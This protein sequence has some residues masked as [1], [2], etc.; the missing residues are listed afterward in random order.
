[1]T[2]KIIPYKGHLNSQRNENTD[3]G[4]CAPILG[5]SFQV[6]TGTRNSSNAPAYGLYDYS[7]YAAIWEYDELG[8]T[9]LN[10]VPMQIT[11]INI[12]IAGYSNGYTYNNQTIKLYHVVESVF[13]NNGQPI[14][15][16][17]LTIYD[18]TIVK[19][20]FTWTIFGSGWKSFTFDTNFCYNGTDNLLLVWENRDGSWASGFGH[21][22][23][24]VAVDKAADDRADNAFPT[25]N[26]NL[27]TNARINIQFKK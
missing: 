23:Y 5:N 14:D 1:M 10:P 9:A 27:V 2:Q 25:G 22:E 21:G 26:A 15:L 16:S 20:N 12:Q 11:G 8:S 18:E 17:N 3:T 24:E 6:G 7:W 13:D 19:E 4:G